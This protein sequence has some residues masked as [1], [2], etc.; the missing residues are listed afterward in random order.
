M[1]CSGPCHQ[2][3][4]ACPTPDACEQVVVFTMPAVAKEVTDEP[5]VRFEDIGPWI[6]MGVVV[7]LCL[8]ALV[9]WASFT[10]IPAYA[11]L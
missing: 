1:S 7:V 5:P 6:A 3:R 9:L 8:T 10:V 11:A 4:I 2:G